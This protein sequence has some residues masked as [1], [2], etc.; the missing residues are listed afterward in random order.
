MKWVHY[1]SFLS[2]LDFGQILARFG[3]GKIW[4]TMR[5]VCDTVLLWTLLVIEIFENFI[6]WSTWPKNL[7]S[8]FFLT[9][10][11]VISYLNFQN[12]GG[13]MSIVIGDFSKVTS[14]WWYC[15]I[16]CITRIKNVSPTS[17]G[18]H[19]LIWIGY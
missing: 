17:R 1:R 8:P 16:S 5:Q 13:I 7:S 14:V 6:L 9:F 15:V 12:A 2:E 11:F 10:Y 18:V 4:T 3:F 19:R